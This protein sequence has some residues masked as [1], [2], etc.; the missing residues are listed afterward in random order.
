VPP[1]CPLLPFSWLSLAWV[2]AFA[3]FFDCCLPDSHA[4]RLPHSD[5]ISDECSFLSLAVSAIFPTCVPGPAQVRPSP[6]FKTAVLRPSPPFLL[7]KKS[8]YSLPHPCTQ[9]AMNVFAISSPTPKTLLPRGKTLLAL[10][11]PHPAPCPFHPSVLRRLAF[12][13]QHN[14]SCVPACFPV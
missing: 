13:P 1:P 6:P 11:Q 4:Y 9:F 5:L 7:R 3:P 8:F 12:M 14:S 10:S 2:L